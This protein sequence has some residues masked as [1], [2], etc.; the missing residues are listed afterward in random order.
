[1]ESHEKDQKVSFSKS[2]DELAIEEKDAINKINAAIT[3]K[4]K[5]I[6]MSKE[7]ATMLIEESKQK[8]MEEKNLMIKKANEENL[9]VAKK[10]ISDSKNEAKRIQNLTEKNLSKIGKVLFDQFMESI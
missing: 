6:A 7:K 10:I 5:I 2:L 3:K 8:S 9:E 4:E 1:M